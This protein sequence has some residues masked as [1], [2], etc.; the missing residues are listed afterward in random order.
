MARKPRIEYAGAV[1]HV[2][3]R[4]DRREAIYRDDHDRSVFLKT[5]G[6][7]CKK[8]GWQ[9]HAYV[10]MG[11]HFHLVVET[12]RA[13]LVAGMRWFMGTYTARFNR[14]HK[15]FGHLF[16]GRY[17][18]LVVDGSGSGYLKSVCDYVHLNPARARLIPSDEKLSSYPWSS[19]PGYLGRKRAPWLRVDRLLGEHRV[20]QDT[21][22][23]RRQFARQ[24]EERRTAATA[25]EW[26]PI[27][28]GWCFGEKEFKQELLEKME[29]RLGPHHA[30]P[31]RQ[32][33]EESRAERLVREELERLGWTE[34]ELKMRKKSDKAKVA[35]ARRLRAETPMTWGW[36]AQ[37]LSMGAG[38][39]AANAVRAEEGKRK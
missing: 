16:S 27:R 38:G 5:L 6:E 11:N 30:L 3:N 19:Y 24:T 1:Y 32:E 20:F 37:R 2:L 8:T 21:A 9:V 13:N 28:R 22:A 36:I 31:E 23:G 15:F 18:A 29:G 26:Q 33:S 35:L 4:G 7:T 34:E 12:P 17:K 39:S 10:L 25:R 14:R